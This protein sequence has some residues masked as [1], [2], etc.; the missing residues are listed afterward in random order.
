M[1]NTLAVATFQECASTYPA[2]WVECLANVLQED[3]HL[4]PPQRDVSDAQ[5]LEIN[6][7]EN[8]RLNL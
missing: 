6:A 4:E 1:E 7:N 8:Y 3:G 5:W 2:M